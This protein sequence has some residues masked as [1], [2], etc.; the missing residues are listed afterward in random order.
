MARTM[1][2]ALF[3]LVT[4]IASIAIRL[5]TSPASSSVQAAPDQSK[6]GMAPV[7]DQSAKPDRL[8]LPDVRAEEAMTL[9]AQAAPVETP[10]TAPEAIKN[11]SRRW[12]DAKDR[13]A[14]S[15]PHRRYITRGPKKSAGSN[16][17]KARTEAWHCRQ[18]AAG[19][20]LRSLDLS[21]RCDL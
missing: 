20:L 19:S 3:C 10:S 7:A 8:E 14:P 16:P 18:D 21:P 1:W 5:A 13:I 15:E 11:P 6:I 12:R 9:A 2:I 4:S 17:P